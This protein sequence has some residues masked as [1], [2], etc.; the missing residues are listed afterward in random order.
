MKNRLHLLLLLTLVSAVPALAIERHQS[1]ISFDEGGT[2]VRTGDEEVAAHRNMP[3][4]PDD[5]I[6]TSRRG[7][8]EVRLSDGNIVG[9]DR[10]TAIRLL[11]ILDSYE[12]SADETVAELRY[13]KVAVY[14]TD[15]GRD[16]VRL[17]TENASYV[18]ESESIYSVETDSRGRDRITVFE[19]SVEVRTPSR[20]TRLRGGESA[21]INDR[22]AFDVVAGQRYGADEFDRWFLARA[23]RFDDRSSRYVDR[24]LSYWTDDLDSYGNWVSVGGVGR[25]WRPYSRA[26]WRPYNNGYWHRSRT[27]CLTWVSYDPWG[28]GTYHYG[29]WAYDPFHGWIWVPGSGYS[30][31]WVYWMYGSGYVGWAPSGYWDC[32]RSNYDW[33]YQPYRGRGMDFGFGFHGRIRVSELD[34][35]PWT[36][37]DSVGLVSNRIDRAALTTDAI[38][39]RLGR[40]GTFATISGGPTRFTNEELRDPAEA[41]RRRALDGKEGRLTGRETGAPATDL[42]PYFRRDGEVSGTIRDR[43]ARAGGGAA[44]SGASN[45]SRGVAPIGTGSPAPIGRGSVA[46]ITGGS[47]APVGSGSSTQPG[48][49]IDRRRDGGTSG[50]IER[51]GSN[52]SGSSGNSGASTS[53][54]VRRGA[55]G[56]T[57]SSRGRD[58]GT[59]DSSESDLRSRSVAIERAPAEP[60][61]AKSENSRVWRSKVRSPA[62]PEGTT[63][64]P[65]APA[66]RNR[67]GSSWRGGTGDGSAAPSGDTSTRS[68]VPRRVI[69]RIG[70]ARIVPRESGSGNRGSSTR[71]TGRSGSTERPVR[72]QGGSSSSSGGSS[73][74]STSRSGTSGSSS[75]SSSPSSG[76]SESGGGNRGSEGTIKRD[77]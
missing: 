44:A 72:V 14:R 61:G 57:N 34:L 23:E 46:P 28:W 16:H 27:G 29:R 22:G 32:Y 75:P 54:T 55:G 19:G 25:A 42:T 69:D 8:A 33:A 47:V 10:A 56:G 36:F 3:V 52:R 12:G 45:P 67:P 39:H 11:S 63:A 77:Q 5:E 6:E 30:P 60:S 38:K 53:G 1:F 21:S 20:T 51:G 37:V 13:G 31:A 18:A 17:D 15:L 41:I 48:S 26:G 58:R 7:R 66:E 50:T 9:I 71:S 74:G 4:Y 35:R 76:R 40:G 59:S 2:I 68:D 64:A 70:G 24:R 62:E 73:A 49:S 43:I 65:V